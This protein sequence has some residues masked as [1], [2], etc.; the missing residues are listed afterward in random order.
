MWRIRDFSLLSRGWIP[1]LPF[2]SWKALSVSCIHLSTWTDIYFL[3]TSSPREEINKHG[4]NQPFGNIVQIKVLK[5]HFPFKPC[6]LWWL[7]SILCFLIENHNIQ[8]ISWTD[9]RSA[10]CSSRKQQQEIIR[11]WKKDFRNLMLEAAEEKFDQRK[12]S[13]LKSVHIYAMHADRC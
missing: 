11:R 5:S 1:Q 6:F 13:F 12:R 4:F 10:S 7:F 2:Y 9:L 3:I 8:L